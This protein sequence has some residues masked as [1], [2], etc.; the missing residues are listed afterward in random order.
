[1]E[2][3]R[4]RSRGGDVVKTNA[5]TIAKQLHH[6][7][8]VWIDRERR[9]CIWWKALT[10]IQILLTTRIFFFILLSSHWKVWN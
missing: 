5:H 6:D 2:Y 4:R 10:R 3:Q 1:M 9:Y 7:C 8:G